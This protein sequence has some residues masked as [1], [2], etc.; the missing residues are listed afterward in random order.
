MRED[1]SGFYLQAQ[2]EVDSGT[3]EPAVWAKAIALEAGDQGKAIHRYVI[4]RAEQ[5]GLLSKE[6]S[7]PEQSHPKS[8]N[9]VSEAEFPE[10]AT[11]ERESFSTND[12]D[13][14]QDKSDHDT[15]KIAL[16]RGFGPEH[17]LALACIAIVFYA[18][19]SQSPML[20]R[21]HFGFL[22]ICSITVLL[23]LKL[24]LNKNGLQGFINLIALFTFIIGGMYIEAGMREKVYA[25]GIYSYSCRTGNM[26][27]VGCKLRNYLMKEL[28][29]LI[30][31]LLYQEL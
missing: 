13:E 20:P 25:D 29:L 24:F 6:S 18:W 2:Q 28:T 27:S 14:N 4:L 8:E 16:G 7:A 23:T 17:L 21:E 26:I 1:D 19:G 15:K 31:Y 30:S 3:K 12:A 11:Q 9:C 5:L 10:G 22:I